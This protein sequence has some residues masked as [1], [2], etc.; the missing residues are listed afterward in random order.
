MDEAEIDVLAYMSFPRAHHSANPLERLDGAIKRRTGVVDILPNEAAIIRLVGALQLE[1]SDEW[2]VPR[3]R[4]M[5]LETIAA[6][7]QILSF[8]S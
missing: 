2:A 6:Q 3:A 5:P 7:M 1:P 8:A 4:Y